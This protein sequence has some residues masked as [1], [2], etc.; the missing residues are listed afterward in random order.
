MINLRR[1]KQDWTAQLDD[2]LLG[3][4]NKKENNFSPVISPVKAE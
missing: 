2:F 3:E 4:D 1:G